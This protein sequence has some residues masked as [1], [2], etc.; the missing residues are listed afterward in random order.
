MQPRETKWA[1]VTGASSE[2]DSA[3]ALQ[4]RLDTRKIEPH[5]L[6]NN[7][8]FGLNSAFIDH[9]PARLRAMHQLYV[10]TLTETCDRYPDQASHD[11][12]VSCPT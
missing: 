1:L 2:L 12:L 8:G 11:S 10:I 4:R 3:V 7:A 6:I 5:I 9:D